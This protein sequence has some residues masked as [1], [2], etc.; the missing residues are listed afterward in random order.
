MGTG[1]AFTLTDV[2][3][4]RCVGTATFDRSDTSSFPLECSDGRT[5][6]ALSTINRFA[7]QQTISYQ[8]SD[9]ETG[10]ITLGAV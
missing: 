8:L 10:S 6:N 2:S 9:G 7:S 3:G 5:G 4:L 1:G